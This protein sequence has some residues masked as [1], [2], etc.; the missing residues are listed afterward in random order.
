MNMPFELGLDDGCRNFGGD[1]LAD[2]KFLVLESEPFIAKKALSDLAGCDFK[3]HNGDYQNIFGIV[4]NWLYNV[5]ETEDT[6]A[7][8]IRY[9]FADFQEWYFE[10]KLASGASEEDIKEYPPKEFL[11][12]MIEWNRVG[13]PETFN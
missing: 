8:Q 9:G 11:D 2:K 1:L 12:G 3:S 7:T 13:R 4:R 6:G 10:K 5:A